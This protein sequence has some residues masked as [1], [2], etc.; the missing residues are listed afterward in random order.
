MN[1]VFSNYCSI[2]E[3]ELNKR[4]SFYEHSEFL[5]ECIELL[6]PDVVP[7]VRKIFNCLRWATQNRQIIENITDQIVNYRITKN[8]LIQSVAYSV[9]TLH[10]DGRAYAQQSI[11]QYCRYISETN[12]CLCQILN[13]VFGVGFRQWERFEMD[14]IRKHPNIKSH[15]NIPALWKK[16]RD[17][18][19]IHKNFDNFDK[20]NLILWGYEKLTPQCIK[21]VEYYFDRDGQQTK[22]TDWINS[23]LEQKIKIAIVELLD[24]IFVSASPKYNPNRRYVHVLFDVLL[25]NGQIP[26]YTSRFLAKD[27]IIPVKLTTHAEGNITIVDSISHVCDRAPV[28]SPIYLARLDQEIIKGDI[29]QSNLG[30]LD[31]QSF[32]VFSKGKLL[33]KYE[34]KSAKDWNTKYFHFVKYTFAPSSPKYQSN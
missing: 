27:Y 10:L 3:L 11:H 21:N 24:N 26:N 31:F 18:I 23:S 13:I 22:M 8:Q 29:I 1:T 16:Y 25:P 7:Y 12:D 32:E 2:D 20:H 9:G 6:I 17:L 14:D 5:T 34:C 19:R 15:S 30:N 4:I 28:P 33:G